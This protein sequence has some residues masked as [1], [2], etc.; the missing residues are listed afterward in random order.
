MPRTSTDGAA[1]KIDEQLEVNETGVASNYEIRDPTQ[2]MASMMALAETPINEMRQA[3]EESAKLRETVV[4]EM[5]Q[6]RQTVVTLCETLVNENRLA[7]KASAD[8]ARNARV[9]DAKARETAANDAREAHSAQANENR[10]LLNAATMLIKSYT[11][12]NRLAREASTSDARDAREQMTNMLLQYTTRT[13]D[14]ATNQPTHPNTDNVSDKPG[15]TINFDEDIDYEFYKSAILQS[16]NEHGMHDAIDTSI[17]TEQVPEQIMNGA[18]SMVLASISRPSDHDADVTYPLGLIQLD[19]Q[20]LNARELLALMDAAF[21]ADEDN[22]MSIMMLS[23]QDAAK[24]SPR[25]YTELVAAWD[26]LNYATTRASSI[27]THVYNYRL[28][29]TNANNI[30]ENYMRHIKDPTVESAVRAMMHTMQAEHNKID[31][32]ERHKTAVTLISTYG[33]KL[34]HL[35]R[36]KPPTLLQHVRPN[37]STTNPPTTGSARLQ[38]TPRQVAAASS[39]STTRTTQ[40]AAST[41]T[42]THTAPA[43]APNKAGA[44]ISTRRNNWLVSAATSPS[45]AAAEGAVRER[46]CFHCNL[47][48]EHDAINCKNDCHRCKQ[49]HPGI[50][51]RVHHQRNLELEREL[52]LQRELEQNNY[53]VLR[54]GS[55]QVIH[56]DRSWASVTEE[57]EDYEID[58]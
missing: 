34:M 18:T 51:C 55:V 44:W 36:P 33:K 16:I 27:D 58:E 25:T 35:A 31:K 56:E 20:N 9:A 38:R 45:A 42:T 50:R 26:L 22:L 40:A 52:E 23:V 30:F 10:L 24:A 32:E 15:T 21:K 29:L 53:H 2:L 41:A 48:G 17:E 14:E 19:V 28:V 8:E 47:I 6:A 13:L 11:N 43:A 3:H 5:R 1:A 54:F 49:R 57:E 12:D 37:V 7:R 39:A 46:K 4:N